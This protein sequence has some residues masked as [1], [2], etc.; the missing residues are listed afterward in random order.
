MIDKKIIMPLFTTLCILIPALSTPTISMSQV[1][2]PEEYIKQQP[3]TSSIKKPASE[4]HKPTTDSEIKQATR[5]SSDS[6]RFILRQSGIIFDTSSGLEWYPSQDKGYTAD[7]AR[8]WARDLAVD[9]GGW[10]LPTRTELKSF[11]TDKHNAGNKCYR[12][13]LIGWSACGWVR[14]D[15]SIMFTNFDFGVEDRIP[16]AQLRV[17]TSDFRALAVRPRR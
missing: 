1:K 13:P 4:S 6:G 3:Q 16:L 5:K 8:Q 17:A 12:T 14:A 15:D 9:G 10:K 2:I 11:V 7:E